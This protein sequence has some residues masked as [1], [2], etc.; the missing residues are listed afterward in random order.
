MNHEKTRVKLV[1]IVSAAL[2][3]AAAGVILYLAG[4]VDFLQSQIENLGG[5]IGQFQND[6][7]N[8]V[9]SI[10][11]TIRDELDEQSNLLSSSSCI[12]EAFDSRENTLALRLEAMPKK[13][14][15]GLTL[16]FVCK[17]G[18]EQYQAEGTLGEGL[19]YTA[20]LE[21]PLKAGESMQVSAILDDAKT[22]QVQKIGEYSG[23]EYYFYP[24]ISGQFTPVIEPI[25][26][27]NPAF[28]CEGDLYFDGTVPESAL[29]VTLELITEQNGAQKKRQMLFSSAENTEAS[30]ITLSPSS[31]WDE[32]IGE[33]NFCNFSG[34]L[35]SS[36][37]S[38][39]AA[40][41]SVQMGDVVQLKLV[42]TDQN[43]VRYKT[44]LASWRI[45]AIEEDGLQAV[46]QNTGIW[47]DNETLEIETFARA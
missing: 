1:I 32:L 29:P 38:V 42:L 13:Y 36:T 43:G 30:E 7:Q 12:I 25:D 16:Q 24:Q 31:S 22:Q 8:Q 45:E 35:P 34:F 17:I 27:Q 44:L 4:K 47:L 9:G 10:A 15:E 46:N 6:I 11:G 40:L 39:I 14:T 23:Y 5:Q 37:D 19:L 3:L 21:V 26:Q 33:M 18:E 20:S 28:I 41:P 2:I